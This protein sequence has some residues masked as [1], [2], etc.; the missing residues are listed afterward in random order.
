MIVWPQAAPPTDAASVAINLTTLAGRTRPEYVSFNF[1]F[2]DAGAGGS[3][4]GMPRLEYLARQIAPTF[5]RVSACASICA[6]VFIHHT[7]A[8]KYSCTQ[9]HTQ[10][11]N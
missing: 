7:P 3:P 2:G 10:R 8:H 5:L 9:T 1:E 11:Q 6:F 4:A